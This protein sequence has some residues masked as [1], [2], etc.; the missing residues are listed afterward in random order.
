MRLVA[1]ISILLLTLLASAA[2]AQDEHGAT[3]SEVF[4]TSTPGGGGQLQSQGVNGEKT[5]WFTSKSTAALPGVVNVVVTYYHCEACRDKAVEEAKKEKE[6]E[7]ENGD[8]DKKKKDDNK[9]DEP[10]PGESIPSYD[11]RFWE[12][13]G[14]KLVPKG[15][16]TKDD[17]SRCPKPPRFECGQHYL[18]WLE[19][20]KH[21]SGSS[22]GKNRPGDQDQI[23]T[24][25]IEM[26][27]RGADGPKQQSFNPSPGKMIMTGTVVAGRPATVT[28]LNPDGTVAAG[29]VLAISNGEEVTT[30]ETD[31]NG[32]ATFTA[33]QEGDSVTVALVGAAGVAATA[34]IW[35]SLTADR[36]MLHAPTYAQVGQ[37]IALTGA[38]LPPGA[39]LFVDG[40][41]VPV[42][43]SSP[44]GYVAL[45]SEDLEPGAHSVVVAKY[46]QVVAAQSFDAVRLTLDTSNHTLVTGETA[47]LDV[48]VDGTDRP[49]AIHAGVLTPNTIAL[50]GEAADGMIV[51]SGG[52]PNIAQLPV[53][54]GMPGEFAIPL[55][56][57]AQAAW[58]VAND[59]FSLPAVQD[60][61]CDKYRKQADKL[62]KEAGKLRQDAK[63]LDELAR[64]AV[65]GNGPSNLK[66]RA[67]KAK[68]AAEKRADK[69]DDR[70]KSYE[71]RAQSYAGQGRTS[72]ANQAR[73][74]A[75]KYRK[76][77][78]DERAKGA[79]KAKELGQKADKMK[80]EGVP[81]DDPKT[82]KNETKAAAKALKERAKD[83]RASAKQKENE[84][85]EQ[86]KQYRDCLKKHKR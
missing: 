37:K 16:G 27:L 41:R 80:S 29:V 51:S 81:D 4:S 21:V 63:E 34:W 86:R 67:D 62:D 58:G 8:Q 69:L 32:Q 54:A 33:P 72:K 13:K 59:L 6:Q 47:T 48:R 22:S 17:H 71:N 78:Q 5:P 3:G 19:N 10:P 85:K 38:N 36:V 83:M 56:L 42:L 52:D 43:A 77:A 7:K 28:A 45:L 79:N 9:K 84:T 61:H 26:E 49:V 31:E 57:D 24:E 44:T 20:H 53:R 73:S 70:A 25:I 2:A 75:Q 1:A 35:D 46:G 18:W 30:V 23:D 12:Y 68:Q 11:P 82:S 66:E 60:E 50:V 74:N 65:R 64:E 40:E 14:G 55:L 15:S 76:A 39:E